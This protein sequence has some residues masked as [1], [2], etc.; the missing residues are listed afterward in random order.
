MD[1]AQAAALYEKACDAGEARSCLDLGRLYETGAVVE[2]DPERALAFYKRA[3]A[4]GNVEG[5]LAAR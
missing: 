1:G 2:A 3:C 4:L 5:C